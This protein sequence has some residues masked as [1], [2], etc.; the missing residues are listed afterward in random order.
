MEMG[1]Q[2]PG[3]QSCVGVLGVMHFV[4]VNDRYVAC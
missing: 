3:L 1:S 4:R 2:C